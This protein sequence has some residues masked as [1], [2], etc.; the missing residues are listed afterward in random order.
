MNYGLFYAVDVSDFHHF[1]QCL[2]G[3]NLISDANSL[4]LKVII[5]NWLVGET[6]E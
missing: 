2:Q 1:L 3:K 4:F 6:F 5:N